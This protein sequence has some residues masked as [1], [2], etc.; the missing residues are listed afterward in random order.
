MGLDIG[1][2]K[3]DYLDRP[4]KH[5]YEFMK[6]LA[7]DPFPDGWGGVW[8]GNS[9]LEMTRRQMRAKARAYAREESLSVEEVDGLVKWIRKLPWDGDTI[10]LHLGW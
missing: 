5:I 7:E 1:V 6:S 10:M 9:M 2:V 3:I 8:E 4:P